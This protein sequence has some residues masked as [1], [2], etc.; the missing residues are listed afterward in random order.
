MSI[1]VVVADDQEV[2]RKGLESLFEN[3]DIEIVA[4]A[5]TGDEA[6]SRTLKHKPAVLLMDVMMPETDGLDALERLRVKLPNLKVVMM[7]AH[8]NPTY[9]ARS[10][11]LGAEAFL[12]KDT[13]GQ[14]I[15]ATVKRAARGEAAIVDARMKEIK[16]R[17][18]SRLDPTEDDVPLTKREYQVL[19][20]LAFGL[21]N[22]EIGRSLKISIETVKEHVQN[23]LRKLD[24][25]DRTEAA[26]W[27][28]KRGLV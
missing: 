9:V 16:E 2:V 21:S 1:K 4:I 6:V 26:V 13:P 14:E 19:R 24:A 25:A 12:L 18:N 28:V 27:A 10:V 8:D 7:S 3:T 5:K 20:H 11:A 23:I 17:L 15:V 22:R